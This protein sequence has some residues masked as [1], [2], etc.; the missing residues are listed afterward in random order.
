MH[1][2]EIEEKWDLWCPTC[3]MELKTK[4]LTIENYSY[5]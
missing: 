1:E 2:P 3:N 5:Q 4:N